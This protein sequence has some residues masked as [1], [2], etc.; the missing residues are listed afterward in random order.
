MI[1]ET[2][3]SFCG[4]DVPGDRPVIFSLNLEDTKTKNLL[5]KR[6]HAIVLTQNEAYQDFEALTK[7]V[8]NYNNETYI[9]YYQNK[10]SLSILAEKTGF[11]E[12]I[13]Y[14]YSEVDKKPI[15]LKKHFVFKEGKW[16]LEK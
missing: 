5:Q 2:A 13:F 11:N 7:E 1:V 10:K 8:G 6:L 3:W 4:N 14:E 15:S 16:T 12:V 9:T